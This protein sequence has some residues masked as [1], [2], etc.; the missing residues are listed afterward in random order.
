MRSSWYQNTKSGVTLLCLRWHV[1]FNVLPLLTYFSGPPS[2]SAWASVWCK[3]KI[4]SSSLYKTIRYCQSRGRPSYNDQNGQTRKQIFQMHK[5]TAVLNKTVNRQISEQYFGGKND[6]DDMTG[7]TKKINK[8]GC[9]KFNV[10]STLWRWHHSCNNVAEVVDGKTRVMM[11]HGLFVTKIYRVF[12]NNQSI[13]DVYFCVWMPWY[14]SLTATAIHYIFKSTFI[15][16]SLLVSKH[17]MSCL[18]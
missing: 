4:H 13:L 5:W 15:L 1:S 16:L 18:C 14:W 10:S 6:C 3:K 2:I 17:P 7:T 8:M 11:T 12:Y 9:S